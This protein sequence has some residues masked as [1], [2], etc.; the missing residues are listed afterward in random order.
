MLEDLLPAMPNLRIAPG[1]TIE[2]MNGATMMLRE[3]PL[4]WDA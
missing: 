1:A 4:E 3:L 2:N